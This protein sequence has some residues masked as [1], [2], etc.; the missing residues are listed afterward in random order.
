MCVWYMLEDVL[1]HVLNLYKEEIQ[2]IGLKQFISV[3]DRESRSEGR[4]MPLCS[5]VIPD[6]FLW[7]NTSEQCICFYICL[8]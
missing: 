5:K 1:F 8:L 6:E 2:T 4:D 3:S 7:V